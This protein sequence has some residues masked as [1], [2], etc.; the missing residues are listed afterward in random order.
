MLLVWS[1]EFETDELDQSK[2][3]YQYGTGQD[4]G[5]HGWGNDELQYYTD[6]EEN[7]YIED[8]ML[9]IVALEERFEG[10][11]YTSARIRTLDKGDWKYGQPGRHYR[12]PPNTDCGLRAGVP[13]QVTSPN[14]IPLLR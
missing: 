11:N 2:W 9:H 5:L 3:S 12:I 7:L 4:E 10:M 14:N 13:V 1:D 8:D 6:R